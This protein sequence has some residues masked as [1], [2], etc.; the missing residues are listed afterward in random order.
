M[1]LKLKRERN[2]PKKITENKK[3]NEE[4]LNLKS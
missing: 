2:N 3:L 4:K 1:S